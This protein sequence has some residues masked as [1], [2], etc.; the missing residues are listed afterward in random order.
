MFKY[1]YNRRVTAKKKFALCL[2]CLFI[3]A[4]KVA[5]TNLFIDKGFDRAQ[6]IS[7]L[8]KADSNSSLA[9]SIMHIKVDSSLNLMA[10]VVANFAE[11]KSVLMHAPHLKPIQNGTYQILKLSQLPESIY[12]PPK[13]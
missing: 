8:Q 1:R 6:S 9:D 4:F 2:L 7:A 13:V 11:A 3:L 12:K 5:A 10:H